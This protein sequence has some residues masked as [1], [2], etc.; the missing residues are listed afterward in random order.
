MTGRGTE[1]QLSQGSLQMTD[2]S[3]KRCQRNC[4][5]EPRQPTDQR[6]KWFLS[7]PHVRSK[8]RAATDRQL[9]LS[10]F[11]CFL[12]LAPPGVSSHRPFSP[13]Q[14]WASGQ[15][16]TP[17]VEL[18]RS[19]GSSGHLPGPPTR[20]SSTVGRPGLKAGPGRLA[21]NLPCSLGQVM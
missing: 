7:L 12:C 6:R 2:C 21:S 17:A 13:L 3:Y 14:S 10:T 9:L 19:S 15:N 5:A 18:G 20:R 4:P 16:Q 1:A 8:P 11:S